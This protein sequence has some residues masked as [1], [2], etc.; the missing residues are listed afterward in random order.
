MVLWKKI[1][2]LCAVL[3][4]GLVVADFIT[5]Q[6]TVTTEMRDEAGNLVPANEPPIPELEED[7]I[8]IGWLLGE[9]DWIEAAIVYLDYADEANGTIQAIVFAD[10]AK[11]ESRKDEIVSIVTDG[12]ADA[13]FVVEEILIYDAQ[14]NQIL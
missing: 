5:G 6:P 7:R 14:G 8:E 3:C 1:I 2:L 4:V 9:K 13:G 11:L 12:I 10:S